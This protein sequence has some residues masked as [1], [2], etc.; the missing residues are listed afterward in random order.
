ME[1]KLLP[2]WDRLGI[3]R[4]LFA[5]SEAGTIS[6]TE[7]LDFLSAYKHED[8]YTVWVEIAT[9]LSK[10]NKL[11]AKEK[12]KDELDAFTIKSFSPIVTKLGWNGNKN[13]LNTDV[14]LRSLAISVAGEAGD[15]KII[16]EAKK[17]FSSI[18][19]GK[20][21]NPDIRGA[22]YRITTSQGGPS[23]YKKLIQKYRKEHLHEEKNRIGN[24]LGYS[25]NKKILESV[26]KFAMSKDVRI[27]DTI[28]ILSSVGT[29]PAG[30]DIWWSFVQKNWETLVSRYGEGGLAL[31]RAVTALSGSA[32]EKHL[33]S[34]KKFFRT[35][36]APG[37]KRSVEQV[38]ERLEGN[39]A[40][41]KRD[42]GKLLAFLFHCVHFGSNNKVVLGKPADGMR[43]EF[44]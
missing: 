43:P 22:V 29:N 25:K 28:S 41:L 39:I 17:K 5:L 23:E 1:E 36:D 34:F 8:N 13:E 44:K 33:K 11:L 2:S 7:A 21:V 4:D 18:M 10:L 38:T 27:Q 37:A 15:K 24:A 35:H 9:G 30:R 19:R 16:K 31:S 42:G 14:L 12:S 6:T 3:I 20:H 26:C 32:E 40:W